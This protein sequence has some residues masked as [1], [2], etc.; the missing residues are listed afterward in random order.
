M[1]PRYVRD[2][3][4]ES[5]NA[6]WIALAI[7]VLV[8]ALLIVL[9]FVWYAPTRQ[10]TGGTDIDITVPQPAPPTGAGPEAT[11][12]REPTP[13][14]TAPQRETAPPRDTAPRDGTTDGG[15]DTGTGT[16]GGGGAEGR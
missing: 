12:P 2:E 11:E 4:A 3:S 10:A 16:T 8:A 1:S 13:D 9:Y 7:V 5:A 14:Q 15:A 6:A